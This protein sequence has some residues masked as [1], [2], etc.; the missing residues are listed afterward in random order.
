MDEQPLLRFEVLL[1][2][3]MVLVGIG[4]SVAQT[5]PGRLTY[6]RMTGQC[7]AASPPSVC[8]CRHVRNAMTGRGGAGWSCPGSADYERRFG[9]EP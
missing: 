3:A 5:V 9:S 6:A 4:A 1:I 2:V 8:A 7:A